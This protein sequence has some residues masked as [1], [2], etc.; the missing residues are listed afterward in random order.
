MSHVTISPSIQQYLSR[1]TIPLRL[2]CVDNSGWARVLSLWYLYDDGLLYCAT[3]DNAKVVTY[4]QRDARCS[5]EVAADEPP[6]CG[7]RGRA[8]AEINRTIGG[9]ILEKLLL[10]YTN[11]LETP[12]SKK[13][14][15]KRESEVAIILKPQSLHTWDYS[16]RMQQVA[17]NT[18]SKACP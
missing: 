11:S 14:L 13:L 16:E 7:V 18:Q 1:I 8:T 10:R 5:F 6:Y 15:S 3:Q 4:L 12:L 9:E 2:S 17:S